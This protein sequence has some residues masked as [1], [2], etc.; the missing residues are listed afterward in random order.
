MKT[1]LLSTCS[2]LWLMVT[3]T[4]AQQLHTDILN[5]KFSRYLHPESRPGWI[6][7]RDDAPYSANLLFVEQPDLIG[8]R[9]NVD[10]MRI[11]KVR[12]DL[13]GNSHF[14][15]AQFYK[16]VRVEMIE[17]IVHE[18]K[19]HVYLA[20]GDFIPGLGIDVNP[21]VSPSAA[22]KTA[23]AV[24]P[25]EKYLCENKEQEANFKQKKNDPNATLHPQAELLIVKADVKGGMEPA[26]FVLA[27]RIAVF[28]E[29]PSTAKYV[30]VNAQTEEV[31]RTRSLEIFCSSG[32]AKTTFNGTQ[33]VQTKFTTADCESSGSTQT[34][35]F[36]WDDC[37]PDTEIKS[38]YANPA[39]GDDYFKCDDNNDWTGSGSSKMTITSLWGAKK[40]Y[41]YYLN[42]HGHESFDGSD[43]LI[44]LFSNR[45]YEDDD[46]NEHCQNAN[47][48]NIIDNLNFGAG[49]DCDP[50][51]TDDYNT[52]DIIG[53]EYTHG[54]IEYAHFDALD[55][56][57]ESGA[58]NESFAD[59]FG[60]MV[61]N[62]VE[63]SIDWLVGGDKTDYSLRSFSD[64]KDKG[65]PD[66][67][68]GD[69]WETGDDDN[70]G[71][72]TNSGVQNFIFFLLSEGGSGTNDLGW[73]YNVT[74]IGWS[75]ARD[76]A[77]QAMMNYLDGD[78]GY[79]TARNAWIQSA[80]DLYGSC[81][82]EVISVG[83]AFMA[84]GVTHYTAYNLASV[85]GT[86]SSVSFIDAAE[87]VRNASV[88]LNN[89]LADCTTTINAGAV[90]TIE[91]GNIISLHPG[92]TA[93]SGSLFTALIDKCEM[94][95][96]NAGDLKNESSNTTTGN[97]IAHELTISIYPNPA[98]Q[99]TN[100]EFDWDNNM[101]V[102]MVVTDVTG[103][104]M[105]TILADEKIGE[106]HFSA[107]VNTGNFSNGLYICM[108]KS[109]DK[110]VA[111]KFIV[112][113]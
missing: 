23:L 43:G 12:T 18:K 13:A 64:P 22:V 14:R 96:Y 98:G 72:H 58:L 2:I 57:D 67:Y 73:D 68:F 85:C 93:N 33:T 71:V 41:N 109:G 35:Y 105:Q 46:G 84:A 82:Q 79:I 26:N 75:D 16:G 95:D 47:Y 80:I 111:E 65:Q 53:H 78:D 70:G 69:N 97:T 87:E 50:G 108:L 11:L 28:A 49:A 32:T 59:I 52:L 100:I 102:D 61:E 5:K 94:S 30:Y 4:Q 34:T 66:T 90:V 77:W 112:Q 74:A 40:A 25:A 31:I 89:F 37:N 36:S 38:W 81:S 10:E 56:S 106:R 1:T 9:N 104:I 48:T 19:G 17:Q 54:V 76:I 51:T 45:I 39:S 83:E 107:S 110:S 24:V 3:V 55:Y 42:T 60:E 20:N 91:S 101:P 88:L 92:F 8:L 44:D 21:S 113:H 27:Y 29:K 7:F 6:E 99:F 103:K 86:Y 15:Y 62:N 63:G